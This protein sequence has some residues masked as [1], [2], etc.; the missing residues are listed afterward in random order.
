MWKVGSE[1]QSTKLDPAGSGRSAGS[2]GSGR[3]AGSAS[4]CKSKVLPTRNTTFTLLGLAGPWPAPGTPWGE[5]WE[6]GGAQG[7]LWDTLEELWEGQEEL[8]E[9]LEKVGF[10]KIYSAPRTHMLGM[11]IKHILGMT[12][13]IL[14]MNGV[15]IGQ[16]RLRFWTFYITRHCL[17]A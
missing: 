8:W 11:P 14:D 5:L 10:L 17:E 16:L 15:N 12:G 9:G 13:D 2:A 7:Q 4:V 1:L 6:S 3:S